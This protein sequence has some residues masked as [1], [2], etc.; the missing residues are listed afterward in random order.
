M[1]SVQGSM[2]EELIKSFPLFSEKGLSDEY[3]LNHIDLMWDI[4]N[5]SLV[6]AVPFYMLW[7]VDNLPNEGELVFG[8]TINALN[9]YARAKDRDNKSTNFRYLLT[10]QKIKTVINF[11]VWC[12]KSRILDYEPILSRANQKLAGS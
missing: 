9:K 12:G 7:C 5:I 3:A 8:N 10:N 1:I 2:R 6:K 4:P 11:L